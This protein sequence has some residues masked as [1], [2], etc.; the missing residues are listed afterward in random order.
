LPEESYQAWTSTYLWRNLYGHE[1]LYA[2]PLFIHQFSHMWIDFRGVQDE[3]MRNKAIDYFENSR[4]ATY[5]QAATIRDSQPER[6][7]R[8]R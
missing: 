3:Y 6:L 7:C 5:I 4:R 8:L 1:F 2:G